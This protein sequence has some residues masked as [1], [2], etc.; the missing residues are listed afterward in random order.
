MDKGT[1]LEYDNLSSEDLLYWQ[2]RAFREWAFR[3]GPMFTYLKM[4]SSDP[5][6]FKRALRVGIEHLEWLWR[7]PARK[8]VAAKPLASTPAGTQSV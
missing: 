7:T 5:R 3:P 4:L 1:V 6:T 2:R 8:A